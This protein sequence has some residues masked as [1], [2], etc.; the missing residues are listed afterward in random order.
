MPLS[1][2][3]TSITL[4]FEC[5][6]ATWTLDSQMTFGGLNRIILDVAD[7]SEV[8]TTSVPW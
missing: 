5:Q 4:R 3:Q 7:R 6:K 1:R 2:E 8:F